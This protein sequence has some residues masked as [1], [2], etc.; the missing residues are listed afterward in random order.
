VTSDAV[1]WTKGDPDGTEPIDM[2][3]IVD[4]RGAFL[5][6][7]IG[8]TVGGAR[9]FMVEDPD[10]HERGVVLCRVITVN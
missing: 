6:Y 4:G 9:A 1:T 2:L 10:N 8:E 3:E 7:A 5:V